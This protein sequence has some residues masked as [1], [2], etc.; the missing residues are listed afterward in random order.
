MTRRAARRAALAIMLAA[1]LPLSACATPGIT[2]VQS[3]IDWVHFEDPSSAADEADAVALGRITDQAGTTTYAEMTAATWNVAVDEWISGGV[4]E[5]EI[6]VTSL[7]RSCGDTGDTMA[8]TAGGDP[9]LLFLRDSDDGWQTITPFQGIVEPGPDGGI[10]AE[11][12]P[13]LYDSP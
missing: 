2:T 7:P 5:A 10:P 8:A 1:S 9:V 11:W 13:D 4:G 3:C 6:V 12:P